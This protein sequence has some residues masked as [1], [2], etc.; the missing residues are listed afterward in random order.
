[1]STLKLMLN[2]P[3]SIFMNGDDEERDLGLDDHDETD[4][5]LI[6]RVSQTTGM[7]AHGAGLTG[8]RDIMNTND[9]PTIILLQHNIGNEGVDD[10]EDGDDDNPA[11]DENGDSDSV[12]TT[13]ENPLLDANAV[14]GGGEQDQDGVMPD[15]NETQGGNEQAEGSTF[16]EEGLRRFTRQRRGSS[17]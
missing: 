4:E 8:V 3:V 15:D 14:N 13:P 16:D 2:S 6:R 12:D 1:M 10:E 11:E 9:D 7:S 5:E 17:T